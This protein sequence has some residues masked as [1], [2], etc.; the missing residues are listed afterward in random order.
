[1]KKPTWTGPNGIDAITVGGKVTVR[2][3][4]TGEVIRTERPRHWKMGVPKTER[5]KRKP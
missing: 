4:D 2:R 3:M 5:K 1:M